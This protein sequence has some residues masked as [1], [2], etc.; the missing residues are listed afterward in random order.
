MSTSHYSNNNYHSSLPQSRPENTD[1]GADT[2]RLYQRVP[3]LENTRR[4]V[5]YRKLLALLTGG[6]ALLLLDGCAI[7]EYADTVLE[8][9]VFSLLTMPAAGYVISCAIALR[10]KL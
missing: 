10:G 6:V 1:A 3:L 2:I 4:R 8:A 7:I 9:T 5:S